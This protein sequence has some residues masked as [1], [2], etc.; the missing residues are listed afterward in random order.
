MRISENRLENADQALRV[1]G[2]DHAHNSCIDDEPYD[3][4]SMTESVNFSIK[5]PYGSSLRSYIW[6]RQF[7][8][9][10]FIAGVYNVEQVI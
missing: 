3:Q 7:I 6:Y 5:R 1:Q 10:G 2:S 9:I 8:A 4:R